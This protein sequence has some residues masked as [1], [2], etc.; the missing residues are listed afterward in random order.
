M[1]FFQLF[2]WIFRF[3]NRAINDTSSTEKLNSSGIKRNFS[4]Q[5]SKFKVYLGDFYSLSLKYAWRAI[6]KEL[7][8]FSAPRSLKKS[9]AIGYSSSLFQIFWWT[10]G[11]TMN[12]IRK[13]KSNLFYLNGNIKMWNAV[14]K[15]HRHELTMHRNVTRGS[16]FKTSC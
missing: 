7:Q 10:N 11:F 1:I 6:L 16:K 14:Y 12:I 2:C 15:L 3:L 5:K 4:Y 8:I 13:Y 9:Y